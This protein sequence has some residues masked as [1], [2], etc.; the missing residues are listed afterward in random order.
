MHN[1]MDNY[2]QC[3]KDVSKTVDSITAFKGS[4]GDTNRLECLRTYKNDLKKQVPTVKSLY[5]GYV[6]NYSIKD[7]SLVQNSLKSESKALAEIKV[8]NDSLSIAGA[9]GQKATNDVI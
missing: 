4:T 5:E 7:G 6:Q 8:Q 9:N 2:E 1:A 3:M